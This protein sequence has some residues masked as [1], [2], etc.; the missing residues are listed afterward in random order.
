MIHRNVRENEFD[1]VKM[2]GDGKL[3]SLTNSFR[4]LITVIEFFNDEKNE[5]EIP[6]DLRLIG[7]TSEIT[8]RKTITYVLPKQNLETF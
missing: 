4:D 8:A 2:P 1:K 5:G 6:E 7:V 3:K